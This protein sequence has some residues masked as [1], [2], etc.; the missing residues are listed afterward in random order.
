MVRR[1]QTP[2]RSMTSRPR[3]PCVGGRTNADQ[4]VALAFVN[5]SYS[6]IVI[7]RDLHSELPTR[8]LALR[9]LLTADRKHGA[10]RVRDDLIRSRPFNAGHQLS[11]PV[12][13][14]HA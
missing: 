10:T 12:H 4:R 7:Q 14:A 9:P 6:D 2:R 11:K 5:P 13:S 3:Q 1:L 8:S